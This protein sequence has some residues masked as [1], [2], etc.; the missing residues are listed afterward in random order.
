MKKVFAS[1]SAFLLVV[2]LFGGMYQASAGNS[3]TAIGNANTLVASADHPWKVSVARGGETVIEG[4]VITAN[5]SELT[6]RAWGGD[7]RVQPHS[8]T[9]LFRHDGSTGDAGSFSVGDSIRVEGKTTFDS[10]NTVHA[11]MVKNRSK[12]SAN[13][14]LGTAPIVYGDAVVSRVD[15]QN[16][17]FYVDQGG[18]NTRISADE[19]T[20]FVFGDRAGG[21]SD[22]KPGMK[23]NLGGL[24]ATDNSNVM[25]LS[26]SARDINVINNRGANSSARV[27]Q[28]ATDNSLND[29][30]NR[31]ATDITTDNSDRSLND[32]SDNSRLDTRTD[33]SIDD[34]GNSVEDTDISPL[35]D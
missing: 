34:S 10:F 1:L 13:T 23:V 27:D 7:W 3:P 15:P 9:R 16:Q 21:F 20:R 17:A 14:V 30:L 29:S 24:R 8:G 32:N 19:R 28:S 11:D 5:G 22:L 25:A 26:V 33:N 4:D 31:Q 35:G 2:G 6:V 18:R 12:H